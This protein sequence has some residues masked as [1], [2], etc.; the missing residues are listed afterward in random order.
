MGKTSRG[1]GKRLMRLV[2]AATEAIRGQPKN[3]ER[4]IR[5]CQYTTVVLPPLPPPV[6]NS[7]KKAASAVPPEPVDPALSIARAGLAGPSTSTLT[8]LPT[9]DSSVPA[10]APGTSTSTPTTLPI[11]P[12]ATSIPPGA[13]ATPSHTQQR[14]TSGSGSG[15]TPRLTRERQAELDADIYNLFLSL[16]VPFDARTC[17]VFGQFVGRWIPGTSW[18]E[19]QQ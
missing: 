17:L 16:G 18:G 9:L 14:P 4:H 6:S 3:M 11:L 1:E 8:S 2:F 7:K 15:P 13:P 5:R 12:A 19:D 10:P